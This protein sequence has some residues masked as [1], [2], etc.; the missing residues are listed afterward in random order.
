LADA[1]RDRDAEVRSLPAMAAVYRAAVAQARGDVDA[2]VVHA[3][4]A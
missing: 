4:R 3:R 2:T 1:A